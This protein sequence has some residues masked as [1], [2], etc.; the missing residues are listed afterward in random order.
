[1][2]ASIFRPEDY[3]ERLVELAEAVL[4]ARQRVDFERLSLANAVA[5]LGE[6][7]QVQAGDQRIAVVGL[8]SFTLR[9]AG[10]EYHCQ[11]FPVHAIANQ[12]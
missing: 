11:V 9:R 4:Q 3:S 5:K 7:L 2:T 6:H 8:L 12:E 1:M 10:D